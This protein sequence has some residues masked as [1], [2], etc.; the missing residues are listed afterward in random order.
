MFPPNEAQYWLATSQLDT[1]AMLQTPLYLARLH[2]ND[3]VP[4]KEK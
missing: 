4:H 1:L 2:K 3:S